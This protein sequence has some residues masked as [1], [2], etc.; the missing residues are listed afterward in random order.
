[1]I[2]KATFNS[3]YSCAS[4]DFSLTM[5]SFIFIQINQMCK[6]SF[7]YNILSLI[8]VNR[9]LAVKCYRCTVGPSNRFANRTQQLCSKFSESDD[10]VIDCPYST[11][12]MKKVF[13][14]ELLDGK[15]VETVSRDCASQK[16]TEQVSRP[17]FRY[18]SKISKI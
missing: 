6:S 18:L 13:K 14:Y 1:M 8:I 3:I 11:M 17:V 2:K 12:C 5:Y 4:E 7:H 15:I 10:Y 9:T 16:Y